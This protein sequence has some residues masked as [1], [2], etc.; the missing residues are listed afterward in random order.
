MTQPLSP[1]RLQRRCDPSTLGFIS[2]EELQP[3]EDVVGQDRATSAVTLGIGMQ[4]EGYN[5]YV[6]GPPGSGRHTLVRRTIAALRQSAA[7]PSDWIYVNNFS[8]PNKPLAITLPPGQ[9]IPFREDMRALVDELRAGIPAVFENEEYA[10]RV[11]AID[12]EFKMRHEKAFSALG[13]EALQQQIALLHTPTG[14]SLAP[15]KDGTVMSPEDFS[16]LTSEERERIESAMSA[17]QLKLEKILRDALRWRKERLERMKMLNHEI[18]LLVAGHL[19]DDLK[20]KYVNSPKLASWFD[21]LLNDVLENADDFRRTE[22]AANPMMRMLHRDSDAAQRYEVNV[23]VDHGAPDGLPVEEVDYPSHPNLVGHIDHVAEFGALVTD[24]RYIRS[25]ALHRAN[26]G[27]L[28]LDADKLLMQPFAWD[29]LKRA[30]LRREIRIESMGEMYSLARTMSLEPETIP[31]DTKVVLFGERRMYYLL[32]AYDPDFD[33][34]FRISADFDDDIGYDADTL[35]RYARLISTAA[36]RDALLP[37][38]NSAMARLVDLSS[39]WSGDTRKLSAD[40]RRAGNVLAEAD[41]Y[42]RA[43]AHARI[44]ADDVQRAS[45]AA[46]ERAARIHQRM[47]DAILRGTVMIDT[48]GERVGQVN[49]LSVFELG[50]H[51]FAEPT[52]ITATTRIGEG[53]V[54][55]IQREVA[56]GGPIHSK[57]VMILSGYLAQ[58]FSSRRPLALSASLVFE[59]MYGE[60][61][62]DSASL[63]E[64]CALLSSISDVPLRQSLAVTGSINQAG[65]V[66]AIGAVNDKIEGFFD[67]CRSRGLTGDQGVIIPAANADHLMLRDDVVSAAVAGQFRVFAVRKIEEAVELLTG[68]PAG[69]PAQGPAATVF[70]RVSER[71]KELVDRSSAARLPVMGTHRGKNNAPRG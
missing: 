30:L 25:G 40:L 2:S 65:E 70:G 22:E 26:G 56:L 29:A 27:Y 52:R 19:I 39:R 36:R 51:A 63:A 53:R 12:A 68:M 4:R 37:L 34:F 59:Q 62:G 3:L 64:L 17:L 23:L 41:H 20:K 67:V 58:T 55:D 1:E 71:L 24:Y 38:H 69:D 57:G 50:G 9:V 14:F 42:A 48:T 35:M 45:D 54:V 15:V 7:R 44:E 11:E 8:N 43:A 31:L 5:L 61:D 49:G 21:A 10:S 47:H 18:T 13:E 46:R 33:K 66:Q 32:Q 16:R 60:V 28:L 6:M